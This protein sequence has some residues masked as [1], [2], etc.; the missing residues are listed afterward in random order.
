MHDLRSSFP[1]GEEQR[2]ETGV[3]CRANVRP[4]LEQQ[5]DNLKV[6][7]GRGP[8]QGGLTFSTFCV[9]FGSVGQ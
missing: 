6:A 9:H 7:V 4:C 2:C 1:D 8:H 3:Q 5:I